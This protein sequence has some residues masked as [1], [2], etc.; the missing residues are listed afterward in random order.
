MGSVAR[1]RD[2]SGISTV[3]E[4]DL[5]GG[6]ES[7]ITWDGFVQVFGW[8]SYCVQP[9]LFLII[10]FRVTNVHQRHPKTEKARGAIIE[11][12]RREGKSLILLLNYCY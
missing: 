8:R 6:L 12:A 3:M 10:N 7:K 4:G 5:T 11:G 1:G 2:D 9:D